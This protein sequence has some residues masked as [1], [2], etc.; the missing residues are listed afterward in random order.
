[1]QGDLL[2]T[3]AIQRLLWIPGIGR[4]LA[5]TIYLEIDDIQRFPTVQHF[6]SYCRLVPGAADSAGQRRH[7]V[8]KH[9]NRYLQ[10]AFGHAA[11]R[12]VPYYPEIRHWYLPWKR[13]KPIRVARALVAT[14][15]A[16]SV[17][18]VLKEGGDCNQEFKGTPLTKRKQASWPRRTSPSA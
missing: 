5:F 13:Q 6:W 8:S 3:A 7:R 14:E 1:V 12:A 18:V 11:V 17:Y 9:G 4:L 10:L 2:E 16:Q 15:V